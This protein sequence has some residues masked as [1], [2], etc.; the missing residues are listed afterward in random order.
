M[1]ER[2]EIQKDLGPCP[3]KCSSVAGEE[4]RREEPGAQVKNKRLNSSHLARDL[5]V[6]VENH[7]KRSRGCMAAA[8]K[9]NT[10]RLH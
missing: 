3:G 4:H 7:F 9:A 6:L 5:G 2:L 1:E 8:K 10:A